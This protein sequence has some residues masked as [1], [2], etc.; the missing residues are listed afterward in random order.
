VT[1]FPR[2][3]AALRSAGLS[4]TEISKVWGGNALRLFEQA[5]AAATP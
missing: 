1:A 4:E 3:T 5:Q 2:I